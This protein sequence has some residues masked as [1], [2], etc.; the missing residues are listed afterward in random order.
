MEKLLQIVGLM[1]V[2][3][4]EYSIEGDEEMIFWQRRVYLGLHRPVVSNF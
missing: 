4:V 2:I 3:L 1:E